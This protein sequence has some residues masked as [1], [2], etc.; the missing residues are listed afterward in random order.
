MTQ[1]MHEYPLGLESAAG[2]PRSGE[3]PLV[4][5]AAKRASDMGLSAFLL[6][7]FS[8]V[9]VIICVAIKIDS[10]GPVFYRARRVGVHGRPLHV[11][12]FRKMRED[13]ST[14]PLTGHSD[15]RF[16]RIGRFLARTK[17][18][19]LPQLWNVLRGQMSLVGPRPEDPGFVA[20]HDSEYR[21]I[22]AVRPGITG[23]GQLA[24]ARE[25]EILD[26]EDSVG[27]YV[28]TILP[29]KVR[30]DVLYASGWTLRGDLRILAWTIFP[31][32][33]RAD[34]AVN[35]RTGTLTRR[36]RHSV[37]PPDSTSRR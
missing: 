37:A 34:V 17:L 15:T 13:A 18:D 23:L 29:Q 27:H 28:N 33:L 35:R 3:A 22:L 31:V 4:S 26:P 12:K 19:E 8:P 16:T 5:R 11:L 9:L 7:L 25:S 30:L 2:V 32:I 20:L 36:R 21:R 10:P 1:G 14:H 24:F 6:L